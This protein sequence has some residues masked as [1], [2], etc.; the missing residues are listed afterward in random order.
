[1]QARN[2]LFTPILLILGLGGAVVGFNIALDI[3]G[4]YRPTH[5]R[6]LVVYGDP[7]VANHL[8]SV[9]Y[10]PKNFDSLLIGFSVSANGDVK[11]IERLHM[12]NHSLNGGTA[13][14]IKALVDM[15]PAEAK[16]R[17]AFVIVQPFQTHAHS[18]E[19]VVMNPE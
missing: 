1:M 15:L 18:F 8:L 19:T 11:P 9:H 3:Y 17:V 10:I 7:R 6:H 5:G 14:E 16:M 4:L 2:W 12:Y 13:I